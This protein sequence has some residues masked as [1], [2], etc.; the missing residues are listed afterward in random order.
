VC[1]QNYYLLRYFIFIIFHSHEGRT[2][3]TSHRGRL[4]IASTAKK[5][6]QEDIE[7]IETFYK[8]LKGGKCEQNYKY[9]CLYA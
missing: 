3:Y 2:W 1:I 8:N 6:S 5:P 4:W 7:R 9:Y